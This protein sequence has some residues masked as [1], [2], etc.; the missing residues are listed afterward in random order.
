MEITALEAFS[1]ALFTVSEEACAVLAQTSFSPGIRYGRD[2]SAAIFTPGGELA[3]LHGCPS[4]YPGL[5]PST[6][7]SILTAFPFRSLNSGDCVMTNDPYLTGSSISQVL[8]ISPIFCGNRPGALAACLARY[9]DLG[10]AVPG[11]LNPRSGEIFHEG[12][13]IAPVRIMSRGE[14]DR[15]L[16]EIITGNVRTG[17]E[18]MGNLRAQIFALKKVEKR[19]MELVEKYGFDRFRRYTSGAISLYEDRMRACL[20]NIPDGRAQYYDPPDEGGGD[21][22]AITIRADVIIENNSL[23]IDFSGTH[24][25]VDRPLN[26]PPGATLA[27]VYSTVT[28]RICPGPPFN[29]GLLRPINVIIPEGSVLGAQFPA[30]VSLGRTVTAERVSRTVLKCLAALLPD[31]VPESESGGGILFALGGYKTAK[32]H[33]YT[34]PGACNGGRGARPFEDGETGTCTFA[35]GD[36]AIPVEIMERDYP[37]LVN[38][39]ELIENSGGPGMYRGGAGIRKTFTLLAKKTSL[40]A[41]AEGKSGPSR[42]LSSGQP[43]R[44]ASLSIQYPRGELIN[45]CSNQDLEFAGNLGEGCV[46]TIEAAGGAGFGNPL[47]RDPEM[48]RED[49]LEGYITI[50]QATAIYGVVLSTPGLEIDPE[51]TALMRLS[52]KNQ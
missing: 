13:R 41:F 50:D 25:Q 21:L 44:A 31:M 4:L 43:G 49:V 14:F 29:Q 17:R 16:V 24:P 1:G 8:V 38:G 37:L 3:A 42:N 40:S 2:C 15:G 7:K 6:V 35:A 48:V 52:I 18:F 47:E 12:L 20:R 22:S 36:T 39:C 46:L 51:A 34:L 45:L 11:G 26:L 32:E 10:G 19:L 9:G 33:Y 23:S 30:P 5:L 28:S 27:C